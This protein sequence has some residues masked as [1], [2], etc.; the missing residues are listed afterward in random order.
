MLD[1]FKTDILG[2]LSEQLDT[3]K[4]Q[5]KQKAETDALAIFCPKCR[6]K[7]AL[8]ECPLDAKVVETCMICSENHEIKDC[9]SIPGLKAVFQE[10]PNSV[11]SLCFVARRPWQGQQYH[12]HSSNCL[13]KTVNLNGIL[14]VNQLLKL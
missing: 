2:S 9:P 11:E 8:R 14:I 1:E 4:I 12:L 5:H 10:D 13:Q 6:K 3:L 7:H